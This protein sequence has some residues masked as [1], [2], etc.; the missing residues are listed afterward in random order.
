MDLLSKQKNKFIGRVI[1][2]GKHLLSLGEPT[3][4][5]VDAQL[6]KIRRILEE[7]PE[8]PANLIGRA[9]RTIIKGKT[10]LLVVAIIVLAGM[11]S[12]CLG[13]SV[14]R[15]YTKVINKTENT[16][17][18]MSISFPNEEAGRLIDEITELRKAGKYEKTFIKEAIKDGILFR[19]YKVRYTLSNGK[20]IVFNKWANIPDKETH[21]PNNF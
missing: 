11:A 17:E 8:K 5:E 6:A 21:K 16:M 9:K 13:A 3:Q 1:G 14:V 20:E 7:K 4:K 10:N 19:V 2:R 12:L 15:I 18:V